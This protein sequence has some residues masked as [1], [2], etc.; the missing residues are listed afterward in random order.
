[1]PHEALTTTDFRPNAGP[2]TGGQREPTP[3]EEAAMREATEA[4]PEPLNQEWPELSRVC[5]PQPAPLRPD[6]CGTCRYHVFVPSLVPRFTGIC[7]LNPPAPVPGPCGPWPAMRADTDW[8]GQW[9][10]KDAY[11]TVDGESEGA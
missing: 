4:E 5:K 9:E 8:C 6:R 11:V 7:R 1:M 3:E 2:D 10:D